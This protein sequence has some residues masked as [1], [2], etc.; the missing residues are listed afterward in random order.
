MVNIIKAE[1]YRLIRGRGFKFLIISILATATIFFTLGKTSTDRDNVINAYKN[2][3]SV[4]IEKLLED[5]NKPLDISKYEGFDIAASSFGAIGVFMQ[6]RNGVFNVDALDYF[7]ASIGTGIFD[8]IVLAICNIIFIGDYKN[9]SYKNI[10]SYGITKSQYY[11][12]KYVTTCIIIFFSLLILR[13][14]QTLVASFLYGYHDGFSNAI[15]SEMILKFIATFIV[16]CALASIYMAFSC[17]IKNKEYFIS[18]VTGLFIVGP[19]ILGLVFLKSGFL[20]TISPLIALISPKLHAILINN[21]YVSATEIIIS[22][23]LCSI[24]II[25]SLL[26]GNYAFSNRYLAGEEI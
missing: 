6:P 3:E 17:F 15:F 18:I 24:M 13:S 10:I 21:P 22:M 12:A 2:Q 7:N 20:Y 4:N 16:Y 9:K 14:S 23:V 1:L 25:L 19:V 5:L 11:L 8:I 26:L